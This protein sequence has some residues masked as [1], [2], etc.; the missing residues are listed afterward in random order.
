MLSS[1]GYGRFR[2]YMVSRGQREG[3]EVVKVNPAFSSSVIGRVKYMERLG[4][5]VHQGAALVLARQVAWVYLKEFPTG[6][7]VL[8]EMRSVSPL[9]YRR[10]LGWGSVRSMYGRCG[11]RISGRLRQAR[12]VRRRRG[13]RLRAASEPRSPVSGG[14]GGGQYGV[15]GRDSRAEPP[16]AVGAAAGEQ[17]R[18]AL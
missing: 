17:L 5:S 9:P 3:V 11:A 14:S 16:C 4:L 7:I 1:L 12:E 18:L 10:P 6:W 8:T 13:P 2:E 15:S